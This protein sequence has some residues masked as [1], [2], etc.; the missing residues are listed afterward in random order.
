MP[1]D[2]TSPERTAASP[3][4]ASPPAAKPLGDPLPPAETYDR[5]DK[6]IICV[7][8]VAFGG[9]LV[10][11]TLRE[12]QFYQYLTFIA[13]L[14]LI[15]VGIL[16]ASGMVRT[17][18]LALGGSVAVYI[19]LIWATSEAFEKSRD[20]K[21]ADRDKQIEALKNERTAL[22]TQIGA[23]RKEYDDFRGQDLA[24]LAHDEQE[25]TDA[26]KFTYFLSSGDDQLAK[27]VGRRYYIPGAHV[28]DLTY[29]VMDFSLLNARPDRPGALDV[30]QSA[31]VKR[32]NFRTKPLQLDLY[33]D[34]KEGQ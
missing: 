23:I 9:F 26:V 30:S 10:W 32:M 20:G 27:K 3:P 4:P 29:I 25:P 7:S 17:S 24:L 28:P 19:G 16:R 11:F 14:T 22:Q 8:I 5:V 12:D 13:I 15:L 6:A 2:L 33:V 31:G 18:W 34:R 1:N 21:I